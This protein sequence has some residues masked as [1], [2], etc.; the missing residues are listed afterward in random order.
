MER[1][2]QTGRREGAAAGDV[3]DE[4]LVRYMAVPSPAL[5]VADGAQVVSGA[6]GYSRRLH[7][8]DIPRVRCNAYDTPSCNLATSCL[9]AGYLFECRLPPG[10][11]SPVNT[12][13]HDGRIAGGESAVWMCAHE[14]RRDGRPARPPQVRQ[15]TNP[16]SRVASGAMLAGMPV[17]ERPVTQPSLR[18]S[19]WHHRPLQSSLL[20]RPESSGRTLF[21]TP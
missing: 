9:S 20:P 10:G 16:A 4:F 3:P 8:C 5:S 17:V 15:T 11:A 21:R 2:V 19:R 13:A 6:D 14:N 12:S 7:A 1:D 18:G